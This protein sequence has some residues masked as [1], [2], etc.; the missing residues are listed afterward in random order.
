MRC[1]NA[2]ILCVGDWCTF[3]FHRAFAAFPQGACRAAADVWRPCARVGGG[4]GAP[5]GQEPQPCHHAYMG[6]K[7]RNAGKTM[8]DAA[9]AWNA[10]RQ[11]SGAR[12]YASSI[13]RTRTGPPSAV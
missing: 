4:V 6:N 11:S 5:Q 7:E 2:R 9:A 13:V 3:P 1:A 12:D 10:V 8:K